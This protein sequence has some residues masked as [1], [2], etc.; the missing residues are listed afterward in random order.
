MIRLPRKLNPISLRGNYGDQYLEGRA[1]RCGGWPD[2]QCDWLPRVWFAAGATNAG[3]SRGRGAC[4]PGTRDERGCYRDE[5]R[6]SIRDRVPSR[7][8]VRRHASTPGAWVED[9]HL[10]RTRYLDLW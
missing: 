5:Y 6:R 1:R 4:P 7:V 10:C 3:R 8:A 9:G 2:C